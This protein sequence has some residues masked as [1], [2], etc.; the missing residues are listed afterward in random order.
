MKLHTFSGPDL[1]S[2]YRTA[3]AA[4]GD[5]VAIVHTRMPRH[6]GERY[7]EV[8]A[9]SGQEIDRFRTRLDPGPLPVSLRRQAGATGRPF[10]IALVGPT[11]AGKTTTAVKLALSPHAFGGCRVGLLTLDTF[12]VGALEQIQTYADVAGM[13]LE[14]VYRTGEVEPALERLADR[15][16]VIVDTPGRGP[17][18]AE[19]EIEWRQVLAALRADEV[20]LVLPATVRTD[21]AEAMCDAYEP[22]GVSHSLLTKLD[23]VP[24]ETGVIELAR[25]LTLRSRWVADGQSVPADLKIAVPRLLDTLGRAGSGRSEAAVA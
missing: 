9:V 4:L 6:G 25:R 17:R 19:E 14:V 2:V 16:V 5:D 12:R 7:V 1:T 10:V 15:D 20:H 3:A 11:G 8:V 23:E 22:A 18:A 13:P 24:G 21:V